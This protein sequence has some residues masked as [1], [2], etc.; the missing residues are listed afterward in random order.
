[1]PARATAGARPVG[2]RGGVSFHF[3]MS[4]TGSVGAAVAHQSYIERDGACVASFGNIHHSYEER[5][6]LWRAL[7]ECTV[8]R[9]GCVRF[10]ADANDELKMLV[11]ENALRWAEEGRIPVRVKHQIA[12]LG[13]LYWKQVD[14]KGEP[15]IVKVWTHDADDHDRFMAVLRGV[16]AWRPAEPDDPDEDDRKRTHGASPLP[17]GVRV[18]RPRQTIL[19]RRIVAELAHELPLDAQERALRAWCECTFGDTGCTWHAVIHQ[20]EGSNDPRN[21]HAHIVYT[22]CAIGREVNADRR[23]TGRFDFEAGSTMPKIVDMGIVLD[24]N[25]PKKQRG[26][27]DLVR[28]WRADMAEEQNAGLRPTRATAPATRRERLSSASCVG[29][30]RP[31]RALPASSSTRWE[32]ALRRA[33]RARSSRHSVATTA[34]AARGGSGSTGFPSTTLRRRKCSVSSVR[35][36]S[37]RTRPM[38]PACPGSVAAS[39]SSPRG[40]TCTERPSSA[41]ISTA[42]A[43][44]SNGA[45]ATR[46]RPR[47]FCFRS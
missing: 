12:R 40:P 29:I 6:R 46:C 41:P 34:T 44:S 39:A 5:C 42:D 14:G 32:C 22:T 3:E 11:Q 27:R 21:W 1:M 38:P 43:R 26:M 25:G 23:E 37:R 47:A 19:Q 15:K 4:R 9:R 28:K 13:P 45:S 35:P 8:Q 36:A 10:T 33:L 2:N 17:V 30:S 31:V 16:P 18:F 7:R 24:G 20:P